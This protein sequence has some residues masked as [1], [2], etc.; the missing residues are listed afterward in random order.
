MTKRKLIPSL[1][2]VLLTGAATG[3]LIAGTSSGAPP[4]SGAAS[5]TTPYTVPT[6]AELSVV[7][8][9]ERAEAEAAQ[10]GS[11]PTQKY[12]LK[13]T[14]GTLQAI[15]GMTDSVQT[16]SN[17]EMAAWLNTPAYLV[18]MHGSEFRPVVS[19]KQGY[20][21]PTGTV[22][23][24]ILDAHTGA[25]LG[26][27]VG[28]EA[29]SPDWK[30]LS[31]PLESNAQTSSRSLPASQIGK[32]EIAGTVYGKRI[33]WRKVI[34]YRASKRIAST[35][36]DSRGRFFFR[37]RHGLYRVVVRR[38]GSLCASKKVTV[39]LLRVSHV[40]LHCGR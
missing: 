17:P 38:N 31:V 9:E 37:V 23:E 4:S 18:Q 16:S 7:A 26:R 32:G 21:E 13:G 40:R 14:F 35:T 8:I 3:L 29:E 28:S 5:T 27:S 11:V 19:G 10:A 6:G 2:S 15:M 34:A 33:G 12:V 20:R 30:S 39:R 22:Y 25:L 36:T 24:V 1:L